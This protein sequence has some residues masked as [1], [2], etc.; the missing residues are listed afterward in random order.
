MEVNLRSLQFENLNLSKEALVRISKYVL[1][2]VEWNWSAEAVTSYLLTINILDDLENIDVKSSLYDI[3]AEVEEDTII[4][5][6]YDEELRTP[7][8]ELLESD[9][10]EELLSEFKVGID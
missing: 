8:K 7:I 4:V 10:Y 3:D 5:H 2:E 6:I 9:K 1:E